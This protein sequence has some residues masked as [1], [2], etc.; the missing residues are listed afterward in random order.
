MPENA[1]LVAVGSYDS[2]DLHVPG[3]SYSLGV[4]KAAQAQ[5]NLEVSLERGRRAPR[6]HLR[7]V[8]A[9]LFE[10]ARAMDATLDQQPCSKE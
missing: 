3:H 7:D 1:R 2:A 4:V 5:G 8:N 6:V 9:G 10:L